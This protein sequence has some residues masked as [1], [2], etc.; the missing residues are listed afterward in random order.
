MEKQIS[1]NPTILYTT[2]RTTN[3]LIDFVLGIQKKARRDT[4]IQSF[5]I[6]AYTSVNPMTRENHI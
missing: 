3:I 5:H 4:S 6:N 2:H 1:S